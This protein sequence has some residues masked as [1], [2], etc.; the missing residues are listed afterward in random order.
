VT[1]GP[2]VLL[3]RSLDFGGAER[4]VVQLA[5]GLHGRGI[6]VL[7]MTFYDGGALGEELV[8]AGVPRSSLGKCGRWDVVGF[9]YRLVQALRRARP[10][11]VYSFLSTANTLAALLRP[12][13]PGTLVVWALR[14]STVDLTQYD[15]AAWLSYRAEQALACLPDLIIANSE[16][17][18]RD[19]L[20][21]GFPHQSLVVVPNGIDTERFSHD[22]AGRRRVRAEWGISEQEKLVGLVAR[23]DPM[24]D[25]AGFLRAAAA[26]AAELPE[27]R[28][29][30][31]G[32]GPDSLRL[33]LQ[34]LAAEVGLGER[35]LWSHPR[36]DM[37][38]VVSALDVACSASSFGEG[39]S[40]ALA[41]AMS[42]GILCI[43]TDVGDAALIIGDAGRVVP[44][45]NPV[46]LAAA[47]TEMLRMSAEEGDAIR[48][49][50]RGRMVENFGMD[51]LVCRTIDLLNILTAPGGHAGARSRR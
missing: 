40:N 45:A 2:V 14:A 31:V 16:A 1:D 37:P 5:L 33:A 19:A 32:D 27:A 41:E 39:F 3:I 26:V 49:R 29:V 28:F 10:S 8:R 11:A 35:I 15:A 47:I 34:A 17:G 6:P 44:A 20:A 7:V 24:K 50:A 51:A 30:C 12:I 9:L 4:Q 25:H 22:E 21:H 36:Q 23:L 46:A 42:C 48:R 18:K 38:A 43:A 13:L